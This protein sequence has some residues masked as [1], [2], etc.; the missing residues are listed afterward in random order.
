[1]LPQNVSMV[2][3]KLMFYPTLPF[4]YLQ[5]VGNL[6]TEVDQT[7]ILGTAPLAIL[8]HPKEL[9]SR[10]V[11]GVVNMCSE[12]AGPQAAYKELGIKQLR[13]PTTDHFEPTVQV[14]VCVCVC[15]CLLSLSSAPLFSSSHFSIPLI[16]NTSTTSYHCMI[17]AL[18]E[19]VAFIEEF[20]KKGDRVYV[21][22]YIYV[23]IY[24]YVYVYVC[25]NPC[26]SL[27][28]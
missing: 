18:H 10:G 1:M 24:V 16:T 23:N 19:A 14:C 5:R 11:R 27:S 17:Q 15:V 25:I 2:V 22:V 12:Y 28:I 7:V 3:S 4:T 6:F 20:H 8:G 9:H 13:L 26:V 21:Y